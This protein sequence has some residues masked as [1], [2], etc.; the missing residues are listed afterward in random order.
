MREILAR[1]GDGAIPQSQSSKQGGR[2][3]RTNSLGN[4]NAW[5][6]PPS[7][8]PP[9]PT[10]KDLIYSS[11]LYVKSLCLVWKYL[12]T[13]RVLYYH[14]RIPGDRVLFDYLQVDIGTDRNIG[15]KW[16]SVVQT[17]SFV[18][19]LVGPH[20]IGLFFIFSNRYVS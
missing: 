11:L 15:T 18:S 4:T 16:R 19:Q 1:S 17:A 20:T 7:P 14:L 6:V 9:P 12:K 5:I 8:P 13:E 2:H 10:Y 3:S